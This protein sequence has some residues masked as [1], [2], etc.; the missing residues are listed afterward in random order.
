MKHDRNWLGRWLGH[1][2]I[3]IYIC[4]QPCRW[5]QM[6]P[7]DKQSHLG[8][9]ETWGDRSV[10]MLWKMS[11]IRS[12]S[13]C[14]RPKRRKPY[15]GRVLIGLVRFISDV[16]AVVK[17]TLT[18]WT[19]VQGRGREREGECGGMWLLII[20][21][22]GLITELQWFTGWWKCSRAAKLRPYWCKRRFQT[23]PLRFESIKCIYTE[24]CHVFLDAK[25]KCVSTDCFWFY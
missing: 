11:V 10:Q 2:V 12:S 7:Q 18:L 21:L 8:Q 4:T 19:S 14:N 3:R 9:R 23:K 13:I 22:C 20:H 6:N 16:I 1:A 17:Q 24:N 15:G 5:M 25:Y